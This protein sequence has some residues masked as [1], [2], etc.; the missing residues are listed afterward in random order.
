MTDR[1]MNELLPRIRTPPVL[2]QLGDDL[3]YMPNA[4]ESGYVTLDYCSKLTSFVGAIYPAPNVILLD[5]DPAR[6]LDMTQTYQDCVPPPA[7]LS[8]EGP[9]D[10]SIEPTAT[11]RHPLINDR[12]NR[13]PLSHDSI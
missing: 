12:V 7:V 4:T 9:F 1:F 11:G 8:Q 10:A 2:D 5:T 6:L 3:T 13:V